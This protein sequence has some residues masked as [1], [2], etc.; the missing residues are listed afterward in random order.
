MVFRFSRKLRKGAAANDEKKKHKERLER[1][2][3]E[4]ELK[5]IW[6]RLQGESIA[7]REYLISQARKLDENLL[8]DLKKL[9]SMDGN[10]NNN[11][12]MRIVHMIN[13]AKSVNQG[14]T[15]E[16]KTAVL[17][18]QWMVEQSKSSA[19]PS[20]PASAPE[21]TP[22]QTL[23]MWN[24]SMVAQTKSSIPPFH[25]APALG[26][27]QKTTQEQ[28]MMAMW[29]QSIAPQTNSSVSVNQSTLQELDLRGYWDKI[30]GEAFGARLY[31]MLLAREV[32]ETLL[33]HWS[34][35][36]MMHTTLDINAKW[37]IMDA[38]KIVQESDHPADLLV[39]PLE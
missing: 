25:P 26:Q 33:D 4:M 34:D 7:E 39:Q 21:Q 20:K 9:T 8:E 16:D 28:K 31:L 1:N 35:Q 11:E 10:L 6:N 30:S 27:R 17:W 12:K 37:R 22:E 24:Q 5:I 36:V 2:R 13:L 3:K 29:N 18:S 38:I 19:P 23:A 15:Q 32:D 14:P